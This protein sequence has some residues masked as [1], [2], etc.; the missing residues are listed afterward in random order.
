MSKYRLYDN[1]AHML[2]TDD[3]ESVIVNTMWQY[4]RKFDMYQFFIIKHTDRDEICL[5]TR[6]EDDFLYYVESFRKT[7]YDKLTGSS[8]VE[9]KKYMVKKMDTRNI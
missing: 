6:S 4:Y 8:C 2:A 9:L 3:N 5:R 7:E 1:A